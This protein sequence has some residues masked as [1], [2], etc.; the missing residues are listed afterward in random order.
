VSS[1]AKIGVSSVAEIGVCSVAE[2][3][4]KHSAG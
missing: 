3:P 1:A 4:K 2:I